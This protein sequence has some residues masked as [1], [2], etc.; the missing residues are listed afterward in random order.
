MKH[1]GFLVLS[2]FSSA[3]VAAAPEFQPFLE[4]H[5]MDCHDG[6]VKKG[7]LD[8]SSLPTDGKDAA[9]LKKWVRVFDRVAAG[10]MPPPKKKQ[11]PSADAV[12]DFMASLGADLSTKYN[13]RKGTVLRR[14]NRNEYQ[15]TI[16]DLLG[17]SVNVTDALP[18]D[19]RAQG[20]DNIGEALSISG[21][22]MLRYMEAAE[23]ALNAA[24]SLETRPEK[25]TQSATL[26]SDRNKENLGKQWLKR[27]DGAIVVFNDGGYPSTV[28]PNLRSK[29][30]GMYKVRVTGYGYQIEEP[31]VFALL[32][33]SFNFRNA[34]TRTRS[35]H[36]LPVGKAGTVEITL[37]MPQ[38]HGIWISA[39]GL[40][41]PDG[42]SAVKDGPDKYPG[43]GMALQSVELEGPFITEWPPR[44]QTL[45]LGDAKLKELPPEKPWM[46]GKYNYKPTYTA[47]CADP[48]A[49]SRKTLPSFLAAA[50][51]RPVSA[52]E[53]EPYFKLFDAEWS[54]SHDYLIA[55]RTAAIG[56][57]CSPDFLYLKEPDG[58]LNDAQL[59]TRLGYFLT[60]S[61]PDAELLAAHVSQPEVMRAQTERL[62]K[63]DRLERFIADFTDGWLNLREI[64]FTT[65]DK[66][67]YPEYDSLLL[68]SM[69]RETRGFIAELVRSNLSVSNL[70]QSDFAMLNSRLARHYGIAGVS[71]LEMRKVKIPD[72]SHR[73]GVLT[74]ASVLKVSANGTNTSPVVRGIFV[75]DRL[76]G[77]EP[78]PPPPGVPGVEPDIRGA[79]TLRELL[80]KH[81]NME[82]CN[83]CHRVIDPPGFAL[84]SYD[85]IG[86]W[87]DR[88]RSIDKGE[89]VNLKVDGRRV[90]YRLGPPV[91]AA[92]EL[93]TGAKFAGMEEF[94]KILL[95]DQDRVAR[96]IAEKILTF[97]TGRAMGFADRGEIDKIV[98]Q[99]KARGH[100][101]RDLILAVVQSGIFRS[102]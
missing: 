93:S 22:Q 82:S 24:F 64:E 12:Q 77:M 25:K 33:G 55:I 99:S 1:F 14:L 45:L 9:A 54:E 48:V 50:F 88:F 2:L 75:M 5:C 46:K 89:Q 85:V 32:T 7:G 69:L 83:G 86:G 92:G 10:E 61:A 23:L 94:Q 79:T 76:L 18:E 95:S 91:D 21:I 15:N 87:R 17:V 72:G 59:A 34:D 4:Q 27:D 8:L 74:Q 13:A 41:G 58:K 52:A 47:E 57:L 51:R 97:A 43:E 80:D 20:F 31:V 40:N 102:K 100:G 62:L 36:E 60:R 96:C 98:T 39:Q 70:I 68:D 38:N 67:L 30:A 3:A 101:M 26:E 56:A 16:N 78:P 11:Q 28:I 42:H 90:R 66:Q 19:G 73:G 81:R 49:T 35:F 65:P 29:A 37:H 63:S 6:E 71:G 53:A 44:A 84:E